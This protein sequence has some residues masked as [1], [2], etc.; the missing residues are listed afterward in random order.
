MTAPAPP[1]PAAV[2]AFYNPAYSGAVDGDPAAAEAAAER[3]AELHGSHPIAA[4]TAG[5]A[6]VARDDLADARAH[7]QRAVTRDPLR[8]CA[9]AWLGITLATDDP[10]AAGER[11]ERAAKVCVRAGR[12]QGL[13]TLRSALDGAGPPEA[14]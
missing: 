8:C 13:K 1:P 2:E 6:A 5:Y 14:S 4:E 7:F 9:N 3:F 12:C 10:A 11:L